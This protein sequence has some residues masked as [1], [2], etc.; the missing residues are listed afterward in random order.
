[1]TGDAPVASLLLLTR[2]AEK[3]GAAG[4]LLVG[5]INIQRQARVLF[6]A[7]SLPVFG[8]GAVDG[9]RAGLPIKPLDVERDHFAD[10]Q[11]LFDEQAHHERVFG[12]E[13]DV[14]RAA[15]ASDLRGGLF[16][17]QRLRGGDGGGHGLLRAP[18]RWSPL[19]GAGIVDIAPLLVAVAPDCLNELVLFLADRL[20]LARQVTIGADRGEA[21]IDGANGVALLPQ[22]GAVAE[23][24]RLADAGPGS[25]IVVELLDGAPHPGAG[26]IGGEVQQVEALAI[27]RIARALLMVFLKR[28]GGQLSEL[29][30]R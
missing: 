16:Q 14:A 13:G 3:Q 19:L 9:H 28:I 23:D 7:V 12:R 4:A 30:P 27:A 10:A 8:F 2:I 6:Q 24:Q 22:P 21:Q 1:M 25:G 15:S 29:L 18:A 20:G 17:L 26:K 5:K 11:R